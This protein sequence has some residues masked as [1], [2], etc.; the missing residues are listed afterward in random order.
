MV[1]VTTKYSIFDIK[2]LFSS[3]PMKESKVYRYDGRDFLD[4]DGNPPPRAVL[5]DIMLK[6]EELDVPLQK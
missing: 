6:I 5:A 4:F 2:Q 1:L 3:T